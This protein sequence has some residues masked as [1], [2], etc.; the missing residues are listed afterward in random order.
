MLRSKKL[1]F[2]FLNFL[3]S[4][5][6]A[7]KLAFVLCLNMF[8]WNGIFSQ[9]NNELRYDT[10]LWSEISVSK[11]ISKKLDFDLGFNFRYQDSFQQLKSKFYQSG[12]KYDLFRFMTIGL[13]FR[14]YLVGPDPNDAFRWTPEITLKHKLGPVQARLRNRYQ[15]QFDEEYVENTWRCMLKLRYKEKNAWLVPAISYETF[16]QLS[17]NIEQ[18]VKNRVLLHLSVKFD[19]MHSFSIDTGVQQE[20][21]VNK[22]QFD[23]I[24]SLNYSMQLP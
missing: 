11:K 18:L 6:R 3:N 16:Y 7:L 15:R 4:K 17:P 22:R 24:I 14:Y 8:I 21:N 5:G 12:V 19:K 1:V 20:I 2:K 13:K 23:R 9:S 10:E